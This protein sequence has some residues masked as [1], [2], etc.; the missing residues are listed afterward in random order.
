MLCVHPESAHDEGAKGERPQWGLGAKGKWGSGQRAGQRGGAGG[1]AGGRGSPPSLYGLT[2][3]RALTWQGPR[4]KVLVAIRVV[5]P[6]TVLL[7][8]SGQDAVE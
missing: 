6:K 5:W 3:P 8:A 2:R 7:R 4:R 1:W